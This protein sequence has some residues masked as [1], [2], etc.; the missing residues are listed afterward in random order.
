MSPTKQDVAHETETLLARCYFY[1]KERP[2]LEF[3]AF[4][5]FFQWNPENPGIIELPEGFLRFN[6][7]FPF[8]SRMKA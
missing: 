5:E 8:G 1:L 4:G 3:L 6:H 7:E 2:F